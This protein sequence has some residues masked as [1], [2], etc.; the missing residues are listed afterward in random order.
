LHF[1]H[2]ETKKKS[3]EKSLPIIRKKIEID[4]NFI[5]KKKIKNKMKTMYERDDQVKRKH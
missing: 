5:P 4:E 3:G 2:A 1:N